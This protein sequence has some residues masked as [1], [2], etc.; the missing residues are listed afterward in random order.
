MAQRV[1]ADAILKAGR[2]GSRNDHLPSSAAVESVTAHRQEYRA[3]MRQ[4]WRSQ[5]E[6]RRPDLFDVPAEPG[7]R[8]FSDRDLAF[9][10]ALAD[11][12]DQSLFE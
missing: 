12:A 6:P 1:R 7:Q 11:D 5:G 8:H 2:S 10:I 3:A 9:P 4:R